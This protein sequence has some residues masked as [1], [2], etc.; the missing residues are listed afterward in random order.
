VALALDNPDLRIVAVE[1]LE[2]NCASILQNVRLNGIE[3]R[4]TILHDAAGTEE[5]WAKAALVPIVY[6]WHKALNQP[7]H[8]M[9]DNRYIGGMVG[10]NTTSETEW[11]RVVSLG[12]ICD[13]FAIPEVALLKID[14]EGCEWFFLDSPALSKVRKVIGEMHV[15]RHG[16][17]ARLRELLAGFEVT[18]DDSLVVAT[19]EAVRR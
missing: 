2:E 3:D 9:A 10:P 5:E 19:F 16:G 17:A 4:V 18:M 1:A 15:G 13:V 6:G 11:C 12:H 8:Y 14:C 7:D